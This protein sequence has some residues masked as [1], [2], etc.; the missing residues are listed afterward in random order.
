LNEGNQASWKRIITLMP[1]RTREAMP[2]PIYE[3]QRWMCDEAVG[4]IA[5]IEG[6]DIEQ[7]GNQRNRNRSRWVLRWRGPKDSRTAPV[8]PHEIRPGDTIIAPASYGGNDE[9][10]WNPLSRAPVADIAETCLAQLIASY[11][12]SAF[13]RPLLRFRLHPDLI[14]DPDPTV[15][16]RLRK[17]LSAATNAATLEEPDT[18]AASLKVL[19]AMK[20]CMQ[21]PGYRSAIDAF[22]EADPQPQTHLYPDHNGFVLSANLSVALA[23]GQ[24]AP[25]EEL[26]DDEP[27]DDEASLA[28]KGRSITLSKHTQAV[29]QMSVTFAEKCGLGQFTDLFRTAARWHD[30]GKRDRRFQA[31]LHGSEIAALAADEPLAKS[32]R[33]PK[34]WGPSDVFGYPV[35]SRHEFVSI[36][37]FEHDHHAANADA[38]LIKLLIGTH[39]GNGRAFA[40]VVNEPKPV[41]VS[42]S[43]EGKTIAVCSDHG[44]YR[45]DS[46]WTDL[47]WRMVRRHGWW[48]LAYLEAL[49]I[50]AD[51]L[52]S[53]QEQARGR[54]KG[55]LA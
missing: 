1:P 10:G 8:E 44:L 13:R 6:T 14:H 55:A 16:T 38:D 27:L 5:D 20:E 17:L 4:D 36:R 32:G 40:T 52:V 51:R 34:D 11:P 3:A 37:L 49:M 46:G 30:E 39:H 2:I 42:R 12:A 19:R 18:W 33:D 45:L 53:A 29:E 31:W 50:T 15:R 35:G 47:F 28:S 7:R 23:D 24:A 22:I 26:E 41:E 43:E 21:E 48:G 9:F 54:H 25:P